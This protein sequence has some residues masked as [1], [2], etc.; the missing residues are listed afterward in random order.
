M[1]FQTTRQSETKKTSVFVTSNCIERQTIT[2]TVSSKINRKVSFSTIET[3]PMFLRSPER[4]TIAYKPES[5]ML[6]YKS[7]PK[8]KVLQTSRR[9][10][11]KSDAYIFQKASENPPLPNIVN[12]NLKNGPVYVFSNSK[13]DKNRNVINCYDKDINSLKDAFKKFNMNVIVKKDKTKSR[14]QNRIKESE[15]TFIFKF[16]FSKYCEILKLLQF[17]K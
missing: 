9:P 6:A 15:W 17:P 13:I 16:M 8:I 10:S 5:K 11:L 12:A 7:D 1:S 4:A 2:T 14:I 3:E